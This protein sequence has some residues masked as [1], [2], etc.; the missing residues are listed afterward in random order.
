MGSGGTLL[1]SLMLGAS[2]FIGG[3][4]LFIFTNWHIPL[5]FVVL[6]GIVGGM[7]LGSTRSRKARVRKSVKNEYIAY[8]GL[9]IAVIFGLSIYFLLFEKESMPTTDFSYQFVTALN[10]LAAVLGYLGTTLVL[11]NMVD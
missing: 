11:A 1:G 2:L 9:S 6:A 3:F 5:L 8:S 4:S 10:L 7:F